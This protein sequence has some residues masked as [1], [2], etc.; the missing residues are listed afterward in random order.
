MAVLTLSATYAASVEADLWEIAIPSI[1]DY[2][3]RSGKS[4]WW[5]P[6]NSGG[7]ARTLRVPGRGGW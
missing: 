5:G 4:P 3:Y 7:S 2:W 1:G 6:I